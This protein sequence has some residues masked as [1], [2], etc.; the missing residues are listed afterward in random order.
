MTKPLVVITGASSGIG[1]ALAKTFSKDGHPLLLLARRTE[2]V[3]A[4]DL[5]N[6]IC[7]KV[8][9]TNREHMIK[10]IRHAEQALGPADAIIN[11]AGCMFLSELKDQNPEDWETMIDVNLRGVFNGIHAVLPAMYQRGSG[12]IINIGSM[13]AKKPFP[14]RAAYGATKVA[15][16]GLSEA[17]RQEVAGHNVRVITIAPGLVETPLPSSTRDAKIREDYEE[18]KRQIGGALD[19]QN[20]AD[21]TL[22]A[23]NQ[24]QTVNIRELVIT[25]TRQSG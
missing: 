22:F 11:N 21:A 9:V 12:T 25:A 14:M 19:P 16:H 2:P 1:A 7:S 17:L 8:D 6:T 4:M 23:Y 13:T 5:P 15:V 18:Q 10:A 24:P 3:M 20:V